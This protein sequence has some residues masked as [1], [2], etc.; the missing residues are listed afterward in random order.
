MFTIQGELRPMK[1]CT[2]SQL[3]SIFVSVGNLVTRALDLMLPMISSLSQK[4]VEQ[5]RFRVE[6]VPVVSNT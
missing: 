4:F 6:S 1:D 2:Q 5:E 3:T